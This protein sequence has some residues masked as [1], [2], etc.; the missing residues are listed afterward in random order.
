MLDAG[1][2]GR[3]GGVFVDYESGIFG[4]RSRGGYGTSE[5]ITAVVRGVYICIASNHMYR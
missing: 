3:E 4:R 5:H 2:R 1:Y